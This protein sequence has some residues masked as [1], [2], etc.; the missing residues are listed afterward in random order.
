MTGFVSCFLAIGS[1]GKFEVEPSHQDLLFMTFQSAFSSQ[2]ALSSFLNGT[3][4]NS[5]NI[6]ASINT[7]AIQTAMKEFFFSALAKAGVGSRNS[8]V[9]SVALAFIRQ[10]LLKATT[11]SV[12]VAQV[13]SAVFAEMEN[14]EVNAHLKRFHTGVLTFIDSLIDLFVPNA[15]PTIFSHA[16]LA[17]NMRY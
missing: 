2:M 10:R 4:I 9:A 3:N 16:H 7:S 6:P 14:R 5:I 15:V 13:V 11:S 8:H 17:V 1:L 12:H